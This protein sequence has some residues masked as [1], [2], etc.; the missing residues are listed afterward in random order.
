M[1][2]GLYEGNILP[3]D[4][5]VYNMTEKLFALRPRSKAWLNLDWVREHTTIIHYCGR[6]EPLER[7]LY[8]CVGCLLP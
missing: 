6:N 8:R 4:P 1:I 2:S 7:K 3:L 5:F